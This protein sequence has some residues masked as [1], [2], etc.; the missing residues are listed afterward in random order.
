[1]TYTTR[2]VLNPFTASWEWFVL[3]G[4]R[5]VQTGT[6]FTQRGAIR[7]AERVRAKLVQ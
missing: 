5:V 6:T 7:K 4:D 2:V 1:M 3:E